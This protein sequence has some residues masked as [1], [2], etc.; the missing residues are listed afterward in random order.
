MPSKAEKVLSVMPQGKPKLLSEISARA[1]I[2]KDSA[3][4]ILKAQEA[5]GSL[6]RIQPDEKTQPFWMRI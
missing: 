4:R 3:L 5:K 1:G 2:S 6:K